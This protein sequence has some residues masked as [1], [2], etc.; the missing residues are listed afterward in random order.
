MAARELPEP[1]G[2]VGGRREH[3]LVA[4][5][6]L[7]FASALQEPEVQRRGRELAR[8]PQ[9]AHTLH[10][11]DGPGDSVEEG[12]ELFVVEAMKMEYVVKAPRAVTID[13][14]NSRPPRNA[15]RSR[16]RSISPSEPSDNGTESTCSWPS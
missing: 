9:P 12:G 16:S 11:A 13:E 4:Q 7:D 3:G 1:V 14:V 5:E 15:S 6:A 8:D 10:G 2:A